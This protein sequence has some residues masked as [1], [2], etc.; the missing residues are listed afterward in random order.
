MVLRFGDGEER[1]GVFLGGWWRGGGLVRF[2]SGGG[3]G[4]EVLG[5]ADRDGKLDSFS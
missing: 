3:G 1:E 2:S 4:W 5:S